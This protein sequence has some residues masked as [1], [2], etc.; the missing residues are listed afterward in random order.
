MPVNL[1]TEN[2]V[3]QVRL[4]LRK[5]LHGLLFFILHVP[6]ISLKFDIMGS[7]PKLIGGNWDI[8]LPLFDIYV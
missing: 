2:P 1:Q 5:S 6:C 8:R 7:F 3:I 4:C